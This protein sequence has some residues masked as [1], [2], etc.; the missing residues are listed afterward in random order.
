MRLLCSEEDHSSESWTVGRKQFN[1]TVFS[2]YF[3]QKFV[4]AL[5]LK[6]EFPLT[7]FI[8]VIEEIINVGG[9]QSSF[10]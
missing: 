8:K 9:P 10:L 6:M 2:S 4:C 5:R 3:L 7:L 1:N